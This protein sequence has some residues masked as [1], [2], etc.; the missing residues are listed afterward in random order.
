[1]LII[2][3][4]LTMIPSYSFDKEVNVDNLNI[5]DYDYQL[6][7][8]KEIL[9]T[10]NLYLTMITSYSFDKEIYVDNLKISNYDY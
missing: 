2:E 5:S 7:F 3:R 4:Y 1:M 9:M 10:I 6:S 8:D